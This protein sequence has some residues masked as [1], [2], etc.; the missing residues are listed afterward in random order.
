VEW[1]IRIPDFRRGYELT[2]ELNGLLRDIGIEGEFGDGGLRP[3]EWAEFGPVQ[4]TLAEFKGAY[5]TFR[6]EVVRQVKD[7]PGV[8]PSRGT[9]STRA[10]ARRAG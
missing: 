3:D 8:R 9:P 1:L 10:G 5:E 6:D 4:K 7:I 2:P